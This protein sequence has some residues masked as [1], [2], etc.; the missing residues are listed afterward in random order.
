MR[1]C[2]S[3]KEQ[4]EAFKHFPLLKK[5][6]HHPCDEVG[7]EKKFL[8]NCEIQ[9]P[10]STEVFAST[11]SWIWMLPPVGKSRI[12]GG[13]FRLLPTPS[14]RLPRWICRISSWFLS[15][16][17]HI[18]LRKSIFLRMHS[19]SFKAQCLFGVSSESPFSDSVHCQLENG[20]RVLTWTQDGC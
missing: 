20:F 1:F 17:Q 5:V 12:L 13:K 8:R 2:R 15:D 14:S 16:L 19:H 6:I 4:G 11:K 10:T 18:L 3:V 7:A 9:W